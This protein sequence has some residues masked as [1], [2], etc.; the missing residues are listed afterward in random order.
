MHSLIQHTAY[1]VEKP[2]PISSTLPPNH[3]LPLILSTTQP[4]IST[5]NKMSHYNQLHETEPQQPGPF[6]ACA[7]ISTEIYA[8]VNEVCNTELIHTHLPS[9]CER[10]AQLVQDIK[11]ALD[12]VKNEFPVGSRHMW[13]KAEIERY[14]AV[15]AN[16]E[17]TDRLLRA[18]D[19][20]CRRAMSGTGSSSRG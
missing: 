8:F 4:I 2:P 9:F 10:S 13:V 14:E 16:V 3:Q 12:L 1:I 18:A 11:T 5:T 19:E 7:A 20:K 6:S 15:V 17:N